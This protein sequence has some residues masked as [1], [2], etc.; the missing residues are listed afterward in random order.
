MGNNNLE[1]RKFKAVLAFLA[2]RGY[3]ILAEDVEGFIVIM[4]SDADDKS[5]IAFIKTYNMFE[6][7]DPSITASEFEAIAFPW[8]TASNYTD[9]SLRYDTIGILVVGDDRAMI[10]HHIN[11]E[12]T[13][14]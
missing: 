14:R 1:D 6:E 11:A 3:D 4:D 5:D 8:V 2:K 12:I 9:V 10:K 7:D 13:G